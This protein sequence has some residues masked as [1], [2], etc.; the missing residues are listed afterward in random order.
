[1]EGFGELLAGLIR[2][3][4]VYTR[5]SLNQYLVLLANFGE[6]KEP[7]VAERLRRGWKAFEEEEGLLVEL[8]VKA[9]EVPNRKEAM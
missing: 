8:E 9:V 7:E 3:N 4:D 5:C 1:M 2:E 6:S